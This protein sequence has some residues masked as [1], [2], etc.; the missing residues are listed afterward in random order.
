MRSFDWVG[1]PLGP[2]PT[3]PQSLRSAVSI[4]LGS[5]F[6]IVIYWGADYVVLYND[7]YAEILGKKHPW[8]LGRPCREVWSEIWDVIAPMLD[9]VMVT[10]EATWSDEQLLILER[11]GY[12]EECYF[13]FSF[14]PVRGA[15]GGV[16]GIFTAVIENT[17]RVLGERRLR[18]LRDLGTAAV[19]ARSAEEACELAAE[20]LAR[21]RADVPFAL[22]YLL[23]PDGARGSLVATVGLGRGTPVSLD[24]FD[25]AGRVGAAGWPLAT[26]IRTREIEIVGDVSGRCGPLPGGPWPESP[27]SALVLP[28]ASPGQ[29]R[30]AGVLVAGV[31][32]RRALDDEYRGFF[33]LVAGQVASAVADARADEAERRRAEALAEL[34]R[35][36]T[37]FFS[38]VSHEFRTPLTLM[39]GPVED[40]L[41]RPAAEGRPENRALLE[42]VHRNGLRLQKLVNALLDFSRIEA[43]RVEAVYEPT[44]LGALTAEVASN[45]RSACERAGLSL[46]TDCPPLGEPAYIDRDMWEKIVLNL[47]SNALKFTFEGEIA[48][49]VRDVTDAVQLTVRDTGIGIAPEEI[50]RLFERFHRVQSARGRT[51]EGTGIGLALVQELVGLHGGTIR[52]ESEPD[53]GST[54]VVSI[55][56]GSA[57]LPADRIGGAR[58]L[59]ST[60][61]GAGPF[62]EEALRWLPDADSSALIAPEPEAGERAVALHPSSANLVPGRATGPPRRARIVWAD[63]NADMREYVSR[64]LGG[65]FDVQAVADGQAALEAAR[66]EPP[67]LVL[68]DIMMPRLDGVG[69]LLELRADPQLRDIPIILLSAR[70]G[71]ESRI[72]GLAAGAADYLVKPFSARELVARVETHVTMGRAR[73]ALRRNER[74]LADFFESASIGLH[75]VGPDGIILRVNQAELDMLGY[76]R[77]EYL[78]HHVAEFHVDRAALDELLARLGRGESVRDVPARLRAQDGSIRDVLISSSALV[79]DGRFIHTRCFTQDVT[80]RKATEQAT[81]LLG[82]I[83]DSSDD[84]IISKDLDGI[85]TSWNKGAERVFGYTAGEAIGRPITMLIPA[86]RLDEEAAIL[87]RLRAG[88]RVEHFETIRVRKDGSP[89]HISLTISP[90]KAADGR[91]VGASKIARDISERR[92]AEEALR[93]ADRAK[94]EFLAMLSHELRN[95]L[96]AIASAIRVLE[97][98]ARTNAT[99]AHAHAVVDRQAAHLTRLVDD[100]LDVTRVTTGRIALDRRAVDLAAFVGRMVAAWRPPGRRVTLDTTPVW[101]EADETRLEQI[102]SNLLGNAVKFTPA[103]GSVAIRVAAEG[104]EAVVR[105]EDTGI[106]IPAELIDR[107]FDLFVQGERSPDRAQGGLGIGLTLVRRLVE[108]HGGRITATSGGVGRGSV[109]TVRLPAIVAQAPVREPIASSAPAGRRRILVVEDNEDAREMLRIVLEGEGH[110][111]YEAA[112]GQAAVAQTLSLAPDVALIDIGLPGLDGYEVA[113]RVRAASAGTPITLVALTGYGRADDRRRAEEAGFDLHLV[114]PVNPVILAEVI[115]SSSTRMPR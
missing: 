73:V 47:V 31:S 115:A 22:L 3:W 82:A 27:S 40:I 113:R 16:E 29:E 8:A 102:L 11:H 97:G 79:E 39:L 71:E 69:L 60:A 84:A 20:I 32:P 48:V 43:G 88:A 7:A 49:G 107:I 24:A 46:L 1:T 72:E 108:Q 80:E 4:C 33:E 19:E 94:D 89:L 61:V 63:D 111:V 75:W 18:A 56:R 91:I 45:F 42:V 81:A 30:L 93:A 100:L 76:R 50:P 12:P 68:A 28:I 6:P 26:V 13:S 2:A 14:S 35:A 105:V 66:A 96:G 86:A 25:P 38:N 83:V 41:A 90:V 104:D 55:P 101:V 95:P 58:A 10:G 57:H 36:K 65:R 52:V 112:D 53:A 106:G 99:A 5:R 51:H 70:A 87:A 67:D 78:G 109:F 103:G 23:D 74:E 15:A 85:I 114:K 98:V 62:V 9:G 110:T 54:F 64:L 37:A 77:E 34:D 21:N 17:R 59:A 44:D 92:R